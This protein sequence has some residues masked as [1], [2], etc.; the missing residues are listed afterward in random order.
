MWSLGKSF[1][2]SKTNSS[3]GKEKLKVE[4]RYLCGG[5]EEEWGGMGCSQRQDFKCQ[6]CKEDTCGAQVGGGLPSLG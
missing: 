6:V 3:V 1:V 2:Q 5:K 4:V